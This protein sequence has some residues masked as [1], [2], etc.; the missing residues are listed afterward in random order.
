[1]HSTTTTAR[2][3]KRKFDKAKLNYTKPR[4]KS[5][6]IKKFTILTIVLVF[7][8]MAFLIVAYSQDQYQNDEDFDRI[9]LDD[10][11]NDNNNKK[12]RNININNNNNNFNNNI[13]NNNNRIPQTNFK[14]AVRTRRSLEFDEYEA[15]SIIDGRV[16]KSKIPPPSAT[17]SKGPFKFTPL[18]VPKNSRGSTTLPT[19][20]DDSGNDPWVNY[21]V[22]T[23]DIEYLDQHLMRFLHYLEVDKIR[24]RLCNIRVFV[25]LGSEESKKD[26]RF[27]CDEWSKVSGIALSYITPKEQ[28]SLA[29]K[30]GA[31][32]AEVAEMYPSDIVYVADV[33]EIIPPGFTGLVL[34]NTEL[35]KSVFMPSMREFMNASATDFSIE[36]AV[37]VV[38]GEDTL[39]NVALFASDVAEIKPYASEERKP[40]VAAKDAGYEVVSASIPGLLKPFTRLATNEIESRRRR[41]VEEAAK[42]RRWVVKKKKKTE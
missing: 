9:P 14:Q 18:I 20:C 37:W 11:V 32:V 1:M 42:N 19:E 2:T 24:G 17:A 33:A 22:T 8:T 3:R 5:Q 35:G 41:S 6:S 16:D 39:Y 29:E 13:N 38:P 34:D 23:P 4:A 31:A 12:E 21:I 25:V 27:V 36:K 30:L 28:K 26:T 40:F 7:I 15:L 10:N